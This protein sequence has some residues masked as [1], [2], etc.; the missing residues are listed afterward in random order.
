[1]TISVRETDIAII[2]MSCRFPGA[3][4]IDEFWHNLRDGVESIAFF[5]KN[6]LEHIDP[7]LLRNPNY[8]KA[9]AVLP[10]I[11]NFDAAFFG[12]S[13]KEAEIMDP[14]QRIILECAWE[15]LESAGYNPETDP[16]VIGVY[17]GSGM[18]TYLINNVYPNQGFSRSRTFLTSTSDLQIRLVNEKDF[19]PTW[20]SYKLNLTGP[21]VNIQ[22]ACS[23]ALV[24]VHIACQSLLNGECDMAL[25]GGV[26][27]CVPQKM[28]Y[29]YQEDMIWSPDGHCRAFDAQAQG[30]VFGNGGGIVVLKLLSQAIADGDCIHAVIKGSAINND[31]ALKVGYTAPSVEGQAAVI[32]EALAIAQIGASTINYIETHGTAT[33]L[34]DSIEIAALTQAFDKTTEKSGFCAIGSVKTNIGHIVEAAGIAGLIKTILALKHQQIPPSLHFQ[35]PNPRIDFANSPFYVNATL[36]EWKT[37]GIPRRAGV[38]AFGMGGTN[39]HLVLEETPELTKNPDPNERPLHILTL[40]ART[41]KAL[42]ELAQNYVANVRSHPDE[43]LADICFT[44]NTGRKHFNHRLAVTA[45]SIEQLCARLSHFEQETTDQTHNL[46]PTNAIAFLFTGQGSQYVNMGRQLYETQPTFRETLDKCNE[47]LLPYLEKPLLEVLYPA[48]V[49]SLGNREAGEKEEFSPL[50]IDQTAY[51]QPALFALEYALFQLWKS[52]GIEPNVVMGHSV[53]EYVAACVAEVFSLEDG[54]KLI[55][56]RGRLM[57]ALP[58]DGE[59]AVLQLDELQAKI[60]IQ[61]YAN[62]VSIAAINGD[63]SIVISGRREAINAVC[64]KLQASGVKTQKLNVSH[65]FHS[66]LMESM[67]VE[68]EQVVRQISFSAPQIKLISN[69]TGKV[70]NSEVATPEYWCTHILKPV[71]FTTS[72]ESLEHLAIETLLEIGPKPILLG[73]GQSCLPDSNRIW[74]S[75]LH[76][77]Q[78]DWQVMLTS[79]AKLYMH[80]ASVNWF[81][82]DR[83]YLRYRLHLPTYPFQR[84]RYWV[85]ADQGYPTQAF[86]QNNGQDNQKLHPLLGQELCLAGTEEIRF[87]SQISPD[88]PVWLKDHSLFEATIMPGTAYLEMALAAGS[89]IAKSDNF[90][91]E[92]VVLQQPM[93]WQE[94]EFK[95]VQ[96]ILTPQSDRVYSFEIY[97]LISTT[98]N[99]NGKL[100]WMLHASGKLFFKEQKSVTEYM[101]LAALKAQCTQEFTIAELYRRF[102]EQDLNYGYSFRGM[103]QLL[104]N[105]KVALGKI[106]LVEELVSDAIDYQLHPVLL[107]IAL[108]VLEAIS[109]DNG[110][111]ISYVPIGLE[112]LQIYKRPGVSIWSHAQLRKV[113]G[114]QQNKQ[115]LIADLQLFAA[116]GELIATV[117]GLQLKAV[118]REAMLGTSQKTWEDWLYEVEWVLQEH[119]TDVKTQPKLD[120]KRNWLILADDQ[121]IGQQLVAR[122]RSQGESCTIIFA[123]NEYE[124]IAEH[125]FRLN[126]ASPE[127]FQQLCQAVPHVHGVVNCWSLNAA[128]IQTAADLD[129]AAKISCGS[130][131]HLVQAML[132]NYSEPPNLWLVTQGAQALEKVVSGVSGL[133]QSPLWGMGQ[134][135]ALEHPELNCV[136]VD[137]DPNVTDADRVILSEISSQ[138]SEGQVAFRDGKRYVA[139]LVRTQPI[140][141]WLRSESFS[142]EI[143]E[144]GIPDNLQLVPTNR[145]QA[146][147]GEVEIRVRATGLNFIDVLDVLGALPFERDN[148]LGVEC[149]GEIVAVG[150]GVENFRVGDA[151]MA[152]AFGSFSKYVTVN[153]KLVAFI[154]DGLNFEQAAAIPVNFVTAYYA[155]HQIAQITAKDKVLIHAAAGGTGMAAVKLALA[156]GS[157]VFATASPGK[158]EALKSIGVQH[159]YNSRTLDFAEQ[160]IRD[161]NGQGV[162]IVLNSL[163]GEGFI[164]KSMWVLSPNGRFLEIAK[165]DVWDSEQV[166]QFKAD[167]SY[168][169]IDLRQICLEKAELV[170]PMLHH[171]SQQFTQGKL[172]L[173]PQKV[174][175]IQEVISAFRYMQRAEHIGKII[176]TQ[177]KEIGDATYHGISFREDSSY[178]ITGGLGDLGLLVARWMVEHG[179]RHLVLVGRSAVKPAVRSQLE[180][181]ELSGA[182]VV[183]AQVDV[184][185]YEQVAQL[186]DSLVP[187]SP[188]LQGIIHTAGVLDDRLLK[189]QNWESFRRVMPPKVQGA[190]NLHTL[191]QKLP[192]EFFVLFSSCVSMLG[193]VGQANYVA[194]NAFLDSLAFYRRSLGL[195]STT[196]NWGAW[197]EVGMAARNQQVI[198]RLNRVGMGAIASNQGLQVLEKLLLEQPIRVGVI[199]LNWSQFREK[200]WTASPFFTNFTKGSEQ[201]SKQQGAIKLARQLEAVPVRERKALLVAHV[202]SHLAQVL[203]WNPS[204]PLDRKRSFFEMGMDSLTSIEL[205]NRLQTSLGSSLPSTLVFDYPT[206]EELVDYLAQEVLSALIV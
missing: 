28:G 183:V 163:T 188:P 19:L 110:K 206:L 70:A 168:H 142:L 56:Q 173:P 74:L 64:E 1:M 125:E 5:A 73:M 3:K 96:M 79:L 120:T 139:R 100:S 69:V 182:K 126:P 88:S 81:G 24:A 59:M 51:T 101:D 205:R 114:V 61:P 67:L 22:T 147:S 7:T 116:S 90:C 201:S 20:I 94:N 85:E 189:Q 121:G 17:A 29:L 109:P 46:L 41:E 97:S 2:G 60:A 6:E 98:K 170:Q 99:N 21:S 136:L 32:S 23:T 104:K 26:S 184:S 135:I 128:S 122:L 127:H 8:V 40:S 68:F 169:F 71:K 131:L 9:G 191:T 63:R 164:E 151:V 42:G 129:V 62:E 146:S 35:Q 165:R 30:T 33:S 155:L 160:V 204:N 37:D 115:N 197:G 187:S 4:N 15:A 175:P 13:T 11:E 194:A 83:D 25:A 200:Q 174:F 172:S 76:P 118:R 185:D 113:E 72:M 159:V 195:P 65:A 198:E 137:L 105:E 54:L 162:D 157:E 153:S 196:I 171:L 87:Q 12:Y 16:S 52:W 80:G 93:I 84:Q 49:H 138:S 50:P 202:S 143:P 123:A 34:G 48:Q 39:C 117:E 27:V 186:L 78:D 193:A 10:N 150:E 134:V 161:T 66:P 144:R 95:T 38:S 124:Q 145:H 140:A 111:Q 156:K 91:L 14:Q 190:W 152:I 199:P 166:K 31:G 58:E 53:G 106:R 57:Q 102:Q 55:A 158:W 18:N 149:A 181:L 167:I 154:P 178:L 107:D 47:I 132:E 119:N 180:Q 203:G 112:R 179:A 177:P 130:T 103:E 141:S 77:D 148:E 108:Q 45:E 192:L 133:A 44:A 82:F 92:E 89:I 176:V 75:S 86:F 36:S 43:K